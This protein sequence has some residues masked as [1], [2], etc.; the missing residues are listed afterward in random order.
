MKLK[1]DETLSNIDFNFNLRLCT[2]EVTAGSAPPAAPAGGALGAAPAAGVS[3]SVITAGAATRLAIT[4]ISEFRNTA[5][6][7][8]AFPLVG[9]CRLAL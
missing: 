3:G 1:H 9:R 4:L 2:L 5:P 6:Q 7:K 8:L